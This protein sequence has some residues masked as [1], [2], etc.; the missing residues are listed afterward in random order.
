MLTL[1]ELAGAGERDLLVAMLNKS[2]NIDGFD[3]NGNTALHC[4]VWEGHLEIARLLIDQGAT[5]NIAVQSALMT[6]WTPLHLAAENDQVECASLLIQSGADIDAKDQYGTTPL[7]LAVDEMVSVS[8]AKLL[9][10]KGA[11]REG[12]L[13]IAIKYS[14]V[15]GATEIIEMIRSENLD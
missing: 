7:M 15:E 11:D 10:Q 12:C 8:V 14:D 6:Q 1:Q 9:L 3:R 2:N 4:A 13:Q 5:L